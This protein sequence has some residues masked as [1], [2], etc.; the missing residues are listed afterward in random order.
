MLKQVICLSH[1]KRFDD[2]F[3][4]AEAD[5]KAASFAGVAESLD[6]GDLRQILSRIF[7]RFPR[8][9]QTRQEFE[10]PKLGLDGNKAQLVGGVLE[11]FGDERLSVV[12]GNADFEHNG[13]GLTVYQ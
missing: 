6:G 2:R 11:L 7:G 9:Q 1:D 3:G 10:L 12:D 13:K 5:I 4:V 8:R